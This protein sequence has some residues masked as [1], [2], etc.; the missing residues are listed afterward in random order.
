[1]G[2]RAENVEIP[3]PGRN[4]YHAEV[5]I[6]DSNGKP[7]KRGPARSKRPKNKAEREAIAALKRMKA[8]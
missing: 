8:V 7:V 5:M 6:R 3:L 1:M 4:V 2:M